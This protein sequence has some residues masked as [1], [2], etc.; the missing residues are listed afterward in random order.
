MEHHWTLLRLH[1]LCD[2]GMAGMRFP[3][4]GAVLDQPLVLLDALS[5][6]ADQKAR[7]KRGPA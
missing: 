1:G 4:G 5:V 6:I 2:M 7:V 3:D